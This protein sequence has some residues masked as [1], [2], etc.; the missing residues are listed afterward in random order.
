M[1]KRWSGIS[2]LIDFNSKGHRRACSISKIFQS[3]SPPSHYFYQDL[4]FSSDFILYF[5]RLHP[6]AMGVIIC[7]RVFFSVSRTN[8]TTWPKYI[9]DFN[10]VGRLERY[11][12]VGIRHWQY[13]WLRGGVYR[14]RN[15]MLIGIFVYRWTPIIL[16][17][18]NSFTVL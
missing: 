17:I 8:L 12:D 5:I 18:I 1:F 7:H 6:P 11:C 4:F 10:E 3:L 9:G 15:I 2:A 13:R 14:Y 16:I